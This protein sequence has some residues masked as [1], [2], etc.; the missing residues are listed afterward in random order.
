MVKRKL[1]F[2]HKQREKMQ[3][4]QGFDIDAVPPAGNFIKNETSTQM[5]L[6]NFEKYFSKQLYLGRGL[7]T[8]V[9]QSILQNI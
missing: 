7:G 1:E 2:C 9:S 6:V 4:Y 5:F 8:K 3:V